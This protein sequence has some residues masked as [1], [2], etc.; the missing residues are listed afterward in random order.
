M[1]H[2]PPPRKSRLQPILLLAAALSLAGLIVLV[3]RAKMP[4]KTYTVLQDAQVRVMGHQ[5]AVRMGT[6][7]VSCHR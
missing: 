3:L 1:D 6:N 5:G 4:G 2:E 7:C